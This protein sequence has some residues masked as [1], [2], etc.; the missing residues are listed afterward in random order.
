MEHIVTDVPVA[1]LRITQHNVKQSMVF[2]AHGTHQG[3]SIYKL[4]DDLPRGVCTPFRL[5]P[6]DVFFYDGPDGRRLLR[7]LAL[8]CFQAVW[9]DTTVYVQCRVHNPNS[10]DRSPSGLRTL[11]EWWNERYC[12]NGRR[13]RGTVPGRDGLGLSTYPRSGASTHFGVRI[14][15][16]G[17]EILFRAL[18][19]ANFVHKPFQA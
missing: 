6:L 13:H 15:H 4:L 16:F 8:L 10:S 19:E 12:Y 7:L 9:R 17:S 3:E 1:A 11:R 5:G 18:I 14:F 2:G